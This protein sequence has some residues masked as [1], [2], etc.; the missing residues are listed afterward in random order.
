M[1]YAEI[2]IDAIV[3]LTWRRRALGKGPLMKV[4]EACK[5]LGI[6]RTNLYQL[7]NRKKLVHVKIGAAVRFTQDDLDAFVEK[8][9]RK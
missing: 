6:G 7:V 5:Y 3:S 1:S 9:R 4:P 2:P 8:S